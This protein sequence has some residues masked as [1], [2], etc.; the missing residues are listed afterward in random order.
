MGVSTRPSRP[1]STSAARTGIDTDGTVRIAMNDKCAAG[2]G[3]RK[4][5]R[6]PSNDAAILTLSARR[7]R[8]PHHLSAPSLPNPKSSRSSVKASPERDRRRH[9]DGRLPSAASLW[10]RK[11][12]RGSI[13]LTGGCAKN[14]GRSRPLSTS[15]KPR[16]STSRPF[17]KI[18]GRSRRGGIRPPE[19]TF[20][21]EYN[22]FLESVW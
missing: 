10:R 18:A 5:W 14:A 4:R 16:S 2:T 21:K 19:G 7:E 17:G 9:P 22:C 13:T 15:S 11:R 3:R 6:A 8:Y 12:A 20:E 1:S